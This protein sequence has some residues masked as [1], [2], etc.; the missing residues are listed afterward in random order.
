VLCA[1]DRAALQSLIAIFFTNGFNATRIDVPLSLS[2]CLSVSP[3]NVSRSYEWTSY[4]AAITKRKLQTQF[5]GFDF[6][7]KSE[8]TYIFPR[9]VLSRVSAEAQWYHRSRD[10]CSHWLEDT[11]YL[12]AGFNLCFLSRATYASRFAALRSRF[13][14]F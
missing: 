3:S 1:H 14:K 6:R 8:R 7:R 4:F 13:R 11:Q 2:L 9:D 5:A 10:V 12:P